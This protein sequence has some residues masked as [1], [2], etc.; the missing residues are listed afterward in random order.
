MY[1]MFQQERCQMASAVEA[2]QADSGW[3]CTHRYLWRP[4]FCFALLTFFLLVLWAPLRGVAAAPQDQL[5][6]GAKR[7]LVIAPNAFHAALQEF[8]AHKQKLHPTE[9]RSLE[10]ILEQSR[11]VDDRRN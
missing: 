9:L 3:S 10:K 7:L 4:G 6:R 5:A 8:V 1:L 11:G 2:G